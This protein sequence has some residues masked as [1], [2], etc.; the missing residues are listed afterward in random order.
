MWPMTI[1]D[2]RDIVDR[3]MTGLRLP[4]M[5]RSNGLDAAVRARSNDIIAIACPR[6]ASPRRYGIVCDRPG[7]SAIAS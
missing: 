7:P 6:A 2:D 5:Y 3:R 4:S 1:H